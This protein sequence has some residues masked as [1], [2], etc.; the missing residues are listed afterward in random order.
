MWT[1]LV[2]L[3]ISQVPPTPAPPRDGVVGLVEVLIP[4]L[5]PRDEAEL[6]GIP[7]GKPPALLT[8][9]NVYTLSLARHRSGEKSLAPTID[10]EAIQRLAK[11][12]DTD[13]FARFREDWLHRD[14]GP[15]FRDPAG[16]VLDLLAIRAKVES[17]TRDLEFSD[18]YVRIVSELIAGEGMGLRQID[19]DR[20]ETSRQDAENLAIQER[21]RY[22]NALDSVKAT[23]GLGPRAAVLP[24]PA[25]LEGFKTVFEGADAWH[26]QPKRELG[27]LPPLAMSLP[28]LGQVK[29]KDRLL[30]DLMIGDDPAWEL[31]LAE[32]AATA[33]DAHAELMW[34]ESLRRLGAIARSYEVERR[35][36]VLTIREVSDTYERILAPPSGAVDGGGHGGVVLSMRAA[37]SQEG[38]CRERLVTLWLAFQKQRLALERA[39]GS[40]PSTD[41]PAFQASLIAKPAPIPPPAIPKPGAPAPVAPDAPPAP[42][43][44]PAPVAPR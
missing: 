35:R 23:L 1:L 6:A 15:A 30:N 13:D 44:P 28:A 8:W 40:L 25:I 11:T 12:R 7:R 21:L 33:K 19:L 2:A 3:A 29:L 20:I 14:A 38:A 22:R 27:A 36:F 17:T 31:A 42:P 9:E 5:G 32:I 16:E 4:P 18:H 24:D 37:K 26:F 34:R 39:T 41:W 10:Q 43:A